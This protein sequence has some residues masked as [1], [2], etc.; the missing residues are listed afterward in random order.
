L[1]SRL[2]RGSDR[3]QVCGVLAA[4]RMSAADGLVCPGMRVGSA[5]SYSPGR[6]TYVLDGW[7]IASIVGLKQEVP[8]G[9]QRAGEGVSGLPT[10]EVVNVRERGQNLQPQ[11]GDTVICKVWKVNPRMASCVILCVNGRPLEQDFPGVLRSLDVRATDIDSVEIYKSCMPGDVLR[12]EVLSLGDA[13]SY[14]LTTAKN[15]LGVISA[16]CEGSGQKMVP[17]SWLEMQCPITGAREAR[18]C[19]KLL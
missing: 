7:L 11:V 5:S 2:A 3:G 13:N 9:G 16:K 8:A 18:K 19:A 10:I 14:Y 17:V 4:A 1:S 12:A 15:E 6:G